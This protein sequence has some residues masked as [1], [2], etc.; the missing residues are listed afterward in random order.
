MQELSTVQQIRALH[1][2]SLQVG[3]LRPF[4][5]EP[6]LRCKVVLRES[7]VIAL[8]EHHR[9]SQHAKIAIRLLA[10]E[11][12]VVFPRSL[13]P[14]LY[15]QIISL[16]QRARFTPRIVQEAMQLPTVVSLVAAGIGVAVIPA[17]LQNIGRTG[18]SY[19]PIRETTP[20]AELAVAWRPERPS[21]LLQL[22]LRV[23]T[24][25]TKDEGE[26]LPST[27]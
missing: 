9:L 7:F 16:C 18:V 8:P 21:L 25:Q 2:G 15:D 6:A 26:G 17:S 3:F 22:F 24:E 13:A 20:K 4:K 5:Q 11:P 23:V 12:F 1:D 27:K 10:G 14:E 19:R